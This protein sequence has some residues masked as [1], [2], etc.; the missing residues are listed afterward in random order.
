M[1][2][3]K[4]WVLALFGCISLFGMEIEKFESGHEL[5]QSL[6]MNKPIHEAPDLS[7][8]A[9]S[10]KIIR[11][12]ELPYQ[13]G[14][15]EESERKEAARFECKEQK[16]KNEGWHICNSTN[17]PIYL[18]WYGV[19]IA[20]LY[21]YSYGIKTQISQ[22]YII[23]PKTSIFVP[24]P[25]L[26]QKGWGEWLTSK[27]ERREL[28]ASFDGTLLTKEIAG[29]ES[30]PGQIL[31]E[32][33]RNSV[34]IFTKESL[35]GDPKLET[36]PAMV[37]LRQPEGTQ[38][39]SIDAR[40]G[41]GWYFKNRAGEGVSVYCRWYSAQSTGKIF[42]SY[43]TR[44]ALSP[45]ITVEPD[46]EMFIPFI[47]KYV[48]GHQRQLLFALNKN[49][50][51][52]QINP[53]A[54][55]NLPG[56]EFASQYRLG[57]FGSVWEIT[58][59]NGMPK[60]DP[61]TNL[62]R[63]TNTINDPLYCAIYTIDRSGKAMR[64][65]PASIRIDPQLSAPLSFPSMGRYSRVLV[66][67]NEKQKNLLIPETNWD[68]IVKSGLVAKTFGRANLIR[69]Y[70]QGEFD[71][72]YDLTAKNAL[73]L[74]VSSVGGDLYQRA[75]RKW[76]DV[77]FAQM[78]ARYEFDIKKGDPLFKADVAALGKPHVELIDGIVLPP[79]EK[80]FIDN[81]S[82]KIRSS[83]N[84][85]MGSKVVDEKSYLPKIALVFSGGGYRAMVQTIGY[86]KGAASKKEGTILD[87]CMY[88]C[89]LSGSTWAINPLVLSA[90]SPAEFADLQGSK[91]QKGGE[92][93]TSLIALV[94]NLVSPQTD[95]QKKLTRQYMRRRF[96]ESRFGQFHGT[97]GLWGHSL[98]N[99]L[100]DGFSLNGKGPHDVTL[101]D[102]QQNLTSN[103]YPLP[104]SVA[105]DESN[106]KERIWYE[107]NPYYVGTHHA[108]KGS[109]APAHL[110]GSTFSNERPVHVAP[111]YPLAQFMGTW[112]SAFA[113]T[114]EDV[115][116]AKGALGAVG[117]GAYKAISATLYGAYNT[118]LWKTP[119]KVHCPYRVA[120]GEYPNYAYNMPGIPGRLTQ[121][122]RLCLIDGGIS[123]EGEY[124]HNFASV[125]ALWR[126]CDIL[127]MCDSPES[128]NADLNS[129]HIR[130]T[131]N[132][133][134]RLGYRFPDLSKDRYQKSFELLSKGASFA[135]FD[136]QD[137]NV[138][139]V[140]YMKCKKNEAYDPSF[141]PDAS[142]AGFTGT[143]NFNYTPEQF[144][145]LSGLTEAIF[146]Q[147]KVL[148]KEAIKQVLKRKGVNVPEEQEIPEEFLEGIE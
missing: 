40:K 47:E 21:R 106:E 29:N 9:E 132:E 139:I 140:I 116:K 85:L 62:I 17:K 101:S 61:H 34:F 46:Q 35:G 104:I 12:Q 105:A 142:A 66:I 56:I 100:L 53:D 31:N 103:Q 50:L 121:S 83:M 117:A 80:T 109:W 28:I 119:E 130:A 24:L 82:P 97:I 120:A 57:A 102:M 54:R 91:L 36:T 18:A 138:P 59:E 84:A 68:A 125:P 49:V 146:A 71:I 144:N 2:Q 15:G 78:S 73:H 81:R 52:D 115:A 6:E 7:D 122:P 128:P 48:S 39:I 3:F 33:V 108:G 32:Q 133:S 107:F 127:I 92:G 30:Y 95:A 1:K 44:S 94:N 5:E 131:S 111:E 58:Q 22:I 124:R 89:G 42:G 77:D 26:G 38:E 51:S 75:A 8:L 126:K 136:E 114:P 79:E 148:I 93:W 45:V 27:S 55:G 11:E 141:D 96:I 20:T 60:L 37:T 143:L 43:A 41:N 98:A 10:E 76:K 147:S 69:W 112:G 87:C 88:M 13:E 90:K 64:F 118:L 70:I 110:F 23:P 113:I 25:I 4:V 86:L 63:V 129:E 123:K 99:A 67:A 134:I 16:K 135:L 137:P 14:I 19:K 74:R 65:G 72:L 145:K